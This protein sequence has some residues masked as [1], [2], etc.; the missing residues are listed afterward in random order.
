[1]IGP[2]LHSVYPGCRG[3]QPSS[4]PTPGCPTSL[5]SAVG[6]V[7]GVPWSNSCWCSVELSP[8]T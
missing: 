8:Q 7:T 3:T 5:G 4:L 1:M 6:E 2:G